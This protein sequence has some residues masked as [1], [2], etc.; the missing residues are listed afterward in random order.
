MMC[1]S[2]VLII[3]VSARFFLIFGS[4]SAGGHPSKV[5]ISNLGTT[6]DASQDICYIV[7]CVIKANTC[8]KVTIDGASQ[9]MHYIL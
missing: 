1:K 9:D 7:K 4:F 5:R 3:G 6:D 2:P 8:P